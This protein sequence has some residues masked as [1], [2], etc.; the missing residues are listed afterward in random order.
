MRKLELI[1]FCLLLTGCASATHKDL[2]HDAALKPY[3]EQLKKSTS[4]EDLN[5]IREMAKSELILLLHGYG[6]GIRNRWIHGDR[7]PALSTFFRTNGVSDPEGASM[8]IIEALWYDLNSNTTPAQREAIDAKRALVARKRASYEKLESECATQLT[9][10]KSE[11]ERCY[12]LYGLPSK[13]PVSGEPFFKLLVGKSGHVRE[14]IFF[15]GSSSELKASLTN[16]LNRFTFSAFGDDE[17]VTLYIIEFPGFC[18][19]AERDTLHDG[20]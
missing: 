3:V 18:R 7:D 8:V 15:E 2:A 1:L 5:R 12:A 16:I 4:P 9:K 10:T 13:N 6:T 14:I 19:V 17:F 20:I 11:F